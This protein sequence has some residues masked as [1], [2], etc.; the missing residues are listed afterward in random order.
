MVS[1]ESVAEVWGRAGYAQVQETS[2][3]QR[4]AKALVAAGWPFSESAQ[5]VELPQPIIDDQGPPLFVP[6]LP[7]GDQSPIVQQI[8]YLQKVLQENVDEEVSEIEKAE[9]RDSQ[10][11][12]EGVIARKGKVPQGIRVEETHFA[13]VEWISER[14]EDWNQDHRCGHSPQAKF[15][16]QVILSLEEAMVDYQRS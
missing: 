14:E 4:V 9:I 6:E 8:S 12:S 13:S 1:G 15:G 16:D 10:A 3:I 7:A 11:R 2:G 5:R